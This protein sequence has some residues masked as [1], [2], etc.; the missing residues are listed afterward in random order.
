[1]TETAEELK[2]LREEVAALRKEIERLKDRVFPGYPIAAPAG[3]NYQA[4]IQPLPMPPFPCQPYYTPN[5]AQPPWKPTWDVTCASMAGGIAPVCADAIA[6]RRVLGDPAA[7]FG[8]YAGDG[9]TE[10]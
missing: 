2:A 4:P 6:M 7:S 9:G 8:G 1:M 10:V 5:T 3:P